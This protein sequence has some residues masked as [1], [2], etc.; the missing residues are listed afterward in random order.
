MN[1]SCIWLGSYRAGLVSHSGDW[2][3]ISGRSTC[4]LLWGKK[5][6]CDRFY[7]YFGFTLSISFHQCSTLFF[8]YMLLT[9]ERQTAMTGEPA[10]RRKRRRRRRRRKKG[11]R[12]RRRKGRRRRRKKKKKRKKKKRRRR[13]MGRKKSR[14]RR[15]RRRKGQE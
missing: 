13:R 11:R 4:D 12:K 3:L 10:K 15:R 14:R 6:H 2:C 5:W 8:M 1:L 7:S 9:P